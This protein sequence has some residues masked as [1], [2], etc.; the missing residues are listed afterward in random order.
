MSVQT[1]RTPTLRQL[2]KEQRQRDKLSGWWQNQSGDWHRDTPNGDMLDKLF[3][4]C[5]ERYVAG[6]Y[7]SVEYLEKQLDN[8]IERFHKPR[9]TDSFGVPVFAQGATGATGVMGP[10][11]EFGA[12]FPVVRTT[13]DYLRADPEDS[14]F[15]AP[16]L[17]EIGQS[18]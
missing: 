17:Q 13:A 10:R 1:I 18:A 3:D 12:S 15:T 9:S 16:P 2:R 5:A 11:G 14:P 7:S 4:R 8:D 6:T